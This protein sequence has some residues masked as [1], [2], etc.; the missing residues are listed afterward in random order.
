[1]Y[2]RK[3]LLISVLSVFNESKILAYNQITCF[4]D[5]NGLESDFRRGLTK[6]LL[7]YYEAWGLEV[8]ISLQILFWLFWSR[9]QIHFGYVE[10]NLII[11]VMILSF[12]S[13]NKRPVV[14]LRP[15]ALKARMSKA[16]RH[17]LKLKKEE[18]DIL[19]QKLRYYISF[20]IIS[21]SLKESLKQGFSRPINNHLR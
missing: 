20:H 15:R 17:R 5:V 14:F 21:T 19:V 1:M 8:Q 12:P 4:I 18:V 7:E 6:G 9:Y 11:F 2:V 10:F 3:L 16:E 13:I